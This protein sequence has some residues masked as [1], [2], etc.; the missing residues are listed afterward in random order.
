MA[1]RKKSD[2]A[3]IFR[4][5]P[6]K[7][8]QVM[9]TSSETIDWGIELL[10]IPSLW[11]LTQGEGIK[12][13]VLDT[14]IDITHPDLADNIADTR[15][16]SG[17]SVGVADMN[18]HG[19]HVAGIIAARRDGKGVV[20][21]AP[22][23]TLLIGKV[24]GDDG[25]GSSISISNGIRWAA[26]SGA[27]IISMSLGSQYP[28]EGIHNAIKEVVAIG[29]YVICAAGNDNFNYVDFPGAFD[30]C[31]AVGSI[32][33]R[34]IIS[35]FSSRGPEVDIVAPGDKILSTYPTRTYA[36]LSGTSMAT[37]FVSGVV[38]LMLAKHKEFGGN[39]PINNLTDLLNHLRDTAID[40][41]SEG[42][43]EAYGFGLINP[44]K[45]VED[46]D[47]EE[48]HYYRVQ[49]GAFK[50]EGN[51]N[52]KKAELDKKGFGAYV[53][54]YDGY[55]RVQCGEFENEDEAVLLKKQLEE[56]GYGTIIKYY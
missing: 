18:G 3:P 36:V 42:F 21:V 5:P 51:A 39:T 56:A 7:V 12:V 4:L 37:P 32:D 54:F 11:R 24:L 17:S 9:L 15:D 16:F 31:V 50:N 34:R 55:Y 27:D 47:E 13:A 45:L 38:T 48:H 22:K 49:V 43:D 23:A 25:Y 41:G 52:R 8:E 33:R 6:F 30:E 28:D 20:G 10:N 26:D 2:N 29:K 35:S 40:L 53:I 19:T 46:T 1:I 44:E 14:G